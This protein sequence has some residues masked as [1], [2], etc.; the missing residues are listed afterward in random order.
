MVQRVNRTA[1]SPFSLATA[2]DVRLEQRERPAVASRLSAK[3]APLLDEAEIARLTVEELHH[4][5]DYYLAVVQRL[6]DGGNLRVMAA[7]G[8]LADAGFLYEVQ[9]VSRGV[10]GRVARTGEAALVEDTRDDPDYLR[11]DA[12]T[13]PGSELSMPIRVNGRVWGVMNLEELA[14]SAFGHDDLLL[15]E[16]IAA[17]VGAALHRHRLFVEP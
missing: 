17:Q 2:V 10:N 12:R 1:L 5:F 16:T 7:A 3:L 9:P 6:E 15:A 14:V 4:S 13:D 8:P 11:R